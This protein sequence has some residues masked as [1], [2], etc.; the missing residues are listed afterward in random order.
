MSRRT[1]SSASRLPCRSEIRA[2]FT[3]G[4][5]LALQYPENIYDGRQR[6]AQQEA[7]VD[8]RR[9]TLG[10]P[11]RRRALIG[12]PVVPGVDP[13]HAGAR[14]PCGPRRSRLDAV[15]IDERGDR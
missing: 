8:L 12:P 4:D 13:A 5:Q 15:A 3:R 11:P 7:L 2:S 1:G 10:Q 14:A 9:E 6:I